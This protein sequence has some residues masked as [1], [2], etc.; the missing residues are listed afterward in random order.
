VDRRH[1][2]HYTRARVN[3]H[4]N[5]RSS[6]MCIPPSYLSSLLAWTLN[7]LV[8]IHNRYIT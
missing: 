6:H 4:R 3:A 1:A 2:S 8:V 5:S 7:M